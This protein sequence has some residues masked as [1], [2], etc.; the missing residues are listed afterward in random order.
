ML[1][2]MGGSTIVFTGGVAYSGALRKIIERETGARVVVPKNPDYAGAIGCC[3]VGRR[4]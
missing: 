1:V 4:E 2:Q 3:V